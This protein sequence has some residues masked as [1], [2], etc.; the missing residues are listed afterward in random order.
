MPAVLRYLQDHPEAAGQVAAFRDQRMRC[1][2]A[3]GCDR[4]RADTHPARPRATRAAAAAPA[5][6]ALAGGASVLLA[7]VLGG[8]GGWFCMPG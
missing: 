4:Q 1:D 7:F 3:L 6:D 8:T 2:P 5:L